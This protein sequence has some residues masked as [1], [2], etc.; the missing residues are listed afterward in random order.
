MK[1]FRQI[2]IPA[3]AIARSIAFAIEQPHDVTVSEM[4]V[5]PTGGY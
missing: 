4:I 5:R 2:A 1:A 3:D